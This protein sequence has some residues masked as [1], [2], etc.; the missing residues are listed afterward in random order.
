MLLM[1]TDVPGLQ[2]S[3]GIQGQPHQVA[4]MSLTIW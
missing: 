3:I 2:A 4:R 1:S